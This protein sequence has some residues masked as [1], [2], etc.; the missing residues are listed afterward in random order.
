MNAALLTPVV[1][2]AIVGFA[3]FLLGKRS[4]TPEIE[5]LQDE[6]KLRIREIE[7]LKDL[8]EANIAAFRALEIDS[9]NKIQKITTA[10]A[11]TKSREKSLQREIDELT[12]D[13]TD[14]RAFCT[15]VLQ[16]LR[17]ESATLPHAVRWISRLQES[18]DEAA[19]A[20][21]AEPP[22]AAPVAARQVREAKAEA[23]QHKREA[24]I[25]RNQVELYEL[26]APWLAEHAELTLE[27]LIEGFKE[28]EEIKRFHAAGDDPARLFL[29]A[30]E[31]SSLSPRE[32]NQIALDRYWEG[33]RR[34]TAWVAGIQYERFVGYLY[35][36]KGFK[37]EYQGALLGKSDLGIDLVCQSGQVTHLVQC[38]RL[39]RG[40][41]IP[42]RE[43]VVAQIYG[44]SLFYAM[45]AGLDS[46]RVRPA[47]YTTYELSPKARDFATLL[48]VEFHEGIELRRYPC[49]KCNVSASTG[50][51]IYHLPFDLQYDRT[52]ITKSRGEC[53]AMTVAEAEKKR[54][55]RAQ[56]WQGT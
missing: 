50:E 3:S 20:R 14:L 22:N 39:S 41:A 16:K 11:R 26:Q 2:A 4:R 36:D 55:R 13:R 6:A 5:R 24:E 40:K 12:R 28:E 18:I 25:L 31:W 33:S 1:I 48:G 56:K 8:S 46:K 52:V 54:F 38:K 47:I 43:N 44:A 9:Q 30:T 17:S 19:V 32:R 21:L 29:S 15:D 34:R 7:Y 51:R 49:V 42:V 27:E 10:A 23:R 37:V 53:Y 35:E 45:D